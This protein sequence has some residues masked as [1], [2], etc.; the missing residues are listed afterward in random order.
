[1]GEESTEAMKSLVK[2][3]GSQEG[4]RHV[5]TGLV[6]KAGSGSRKQNPTAPEQRG[7]AS[8]HMT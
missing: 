2:L 1:M 8:T 4:G 5:G 6:G 3:G 7:L